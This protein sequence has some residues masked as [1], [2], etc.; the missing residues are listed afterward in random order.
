MDYRVGTSVIL[1]T[2]NWGI[3]QGVVFGLNITML[4]N[5]KLRNG[6]NKFKLHFQTHATHT[7]FSWYRNK[8]KI[9]VLFMKKHTF[10]T[11]CTSMAFM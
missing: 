4:S 7:C 1:F 8:T 6:K 9:F 11:K 3:H 10:S 5:K 2:M